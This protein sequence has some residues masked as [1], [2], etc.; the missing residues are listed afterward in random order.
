MADAIGLVDDEELG[1][2]VRLPALFPLETDRRSEAQVCHK[3]SNEEDDNERL[4]SLVGTIRSYI[5]GFQGP[6][7]KDVS[8]TGFAIQSLSL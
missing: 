7:S 5:V 3:R 2:E 4:S 8:P 6:G 1:P